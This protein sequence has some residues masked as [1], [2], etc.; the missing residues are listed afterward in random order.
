[1]ST[2]VTGGAGFIGGNLVGRLH[3]AGAEVV[4]YD[5][6]PR[7]RPFPQGV[8]AVPGEL[9]DQSRLAATIA[10][11][12]VER[13]V[14]AAG[15]SDPLLSLGMPAATVTANATGTLHV[16]EAARL[17]NFRG[18]IVLLSSTAV[19]GDNA[20]PIDESAPLRP[21]TPFAAAKALGD[22]LASVYI[23]RF[24]LDVV[25]LRLS[26]VYG[27]GAGHD[28]LFQEIVCAALG[29]QHLQV[30]AG[31]EQLYHLVHVE[32][33]SRAVVA[34]LDA[35]DPVS[36]VYNVSGGDHSALG[37]VVALVRDQLPSAAIELG[38][39]R[40]DRL[41][42]QGTIDNRA[43]DRELG[44]RPRWGLARGIDDLFVWHESNLALTLTRGAA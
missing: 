19:Y 30:G 13:V 32:D 38:S 20:G 40:L 11:N 44:Y 39:G 31:A 15:M 2:L 33:A 24:G 4:S 41:D 22:L 9:F 29:A 6:G 3:D 28:S 18:R 35:R 34:A 25:S 12:G 27:P 17:A 21:R 26:E 1:M 36:R 43:A 23:D 42:D 14:H 37:Q 8:T 7:S 5:R 10:K 16:L